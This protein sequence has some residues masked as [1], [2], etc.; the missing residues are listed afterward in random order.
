M[1][2]DRQKTTQGKRR[3]I[4][5]EKARWGRSCIEAMSICVA[6]WKLGRSHLSKASKIL[7]GQAAPPTMT[8]LR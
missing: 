3:A 7:R 4:P 8:I 6:Y 2:D 5:A 1:V